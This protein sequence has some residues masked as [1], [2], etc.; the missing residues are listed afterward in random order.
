VDKKSAKAMLM[1]LCTGFCIGVAF[2]TGSAIA[3]AA[4]GLNIACL[5][6]ARVQKKI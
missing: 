1:L 4:V 6:S 2:I 5:I 3:I